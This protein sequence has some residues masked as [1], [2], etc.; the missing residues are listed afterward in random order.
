[1][2]VY[3]LDERTK[4]RAAR[5]CVSGGVPATA[6]HAPARPDAKLLISLTRCKKKLPSPGQRQIR[7]C[8]IR[9][10][11]APPATAARQCPLR[12]PARGAARRGGRAPPGRQGLP[13]LHLQVR[14]RRRFG[15]AP[16]ISSAPNADRCAGGAAS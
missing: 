2:Q 16:C 5:V 15:C 1:V 6:L 9:S 14:G 13:L 7:P 3:F 4:A 10:A 12:Q 11:A 8:R